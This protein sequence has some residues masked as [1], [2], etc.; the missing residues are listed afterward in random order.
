MNR[1]IQR[2]CR[3]RR[4][5]ELS[6]SIREHLDETIEELVDNGMTREDAA[7][8]ARRQFGNVALLE[9]RSREVWQWPTIESVWADVKFALRQLRRSPGFTIVSLLTLAL[10][11]GANTAVYSII[12]A[13]LLHPLPYHDPNRLML[14]A[15]KQDPQEGGVLYKDYETWRKH[16]SSFTDEQPITG[17]AVG[18]GRR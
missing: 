15:D 5:S 1:F 2:F 14:L 4:Y 7:R 16:T 9:E 8:A 3:R 11:I 6:Q 10:G 18:R 17:I 12:Q 13:V